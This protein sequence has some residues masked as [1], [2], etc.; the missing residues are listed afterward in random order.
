MKARRKLDGNLTVR[1]KQDLV[2]F[3]NQAEQAPRPLFPASLRLNTIRR[4]LASA[5]P[6]QC[7]NARETDPDDILI[8]IAALATRRKG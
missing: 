1:P 4:G 3:A 7:V 6:A 5:D 8:Q 2:H